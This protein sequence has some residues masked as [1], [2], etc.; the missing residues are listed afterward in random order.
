MAT[1][2]RRNAASVDLALARRLERAEGLANRRFIEAKQKAFPGTTA[3]WIEAAGTYAMFDSAQSPLTQT[4]GL[5]MFGNPTDEEFER[6]ETFFLE[7]QATVFHEVSPVADP[8]LVERLRMRGYFPIELTNLMSCPVAELVP[9]STNPDLHVREV[10][11]GEQ[12]AYTELA[13]KGWELPPEFSA[14]FEDMAKANQHNVHVASFIVEEQGQW[15]GCGALCLSDDVGLIAGDCTLPEARGK[16]A[17]LAL[18]AGR[19]EFARKRGIDLIMMGALPG[20][21]SQ[22]N[23]QRAGLDIAYTRIKWQKA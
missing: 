14:F 22:K 20:S 18:I 4:F 13:K 2:T 23:G 12:E 10:S 5:G 11:P 6:L 15:I 9:L 3:A 8:A 1:P 21:S 19:I 7:R 17:Q 16:G